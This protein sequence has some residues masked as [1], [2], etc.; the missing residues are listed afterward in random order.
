MTGDHASPNSLYQ[1]QPFGRT[2]VL[3][4]FAPADIS[5][6]PLLP[7]RTAQILRKEWDRRASGS[8]SLIDVIPAEDT[9][10]IRFDDAIDQASVDQLDQLIGNAQTSGAAIPIPPTIV[11][12]PVVI[13]VTYNGADLADISAQCGISVDRLIDTHVNTDFTVAF[14][15]FAP[16]FAYLTG[17]PDA[18]H[19]PRRHTPRTRVPAGSVAIAEHYSAV[20]PQESPGGWHLIGHTDLTLFDPRHDAPPLLRPGMTV[21]FAHAGERIEIA[22]D[23]LSSAAST[24]PTATLSPEP[25]ASTPAGARIHATGMGCVIEDLGRPGWGHLAISESGAW[26]R[27]SHRLAQRLV[28]NDENAAGL[29]CVAGGLHLR[30][31]EP[32]TVAITGAPG[33]AWISRADTDIAVSTHIPL[34]LAAGESLRIGMPTSGLRRYVAIRGGIQAMSMFDSRSTD[35]LSGLGPAPLDAGAHLHFGQATHEVPGIDAMAPDPV[36]SDAAMIPTAN[37]SLLHPATREHLASGSFHMSAASDRVGIRLV[38]PAAQWLPD[39]RVT[40]L[41]RPMI[42][43]AIQMPPDG[44]PVVFGPDHPA[45]GGYPIIGVLADPDAPAQ[46]APG[47]TV[48]L[49]EVIPFHLA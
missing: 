15:G 43:G 18:L 40:A 23:P 4:T 47:V 48:A 32:L 42:R 39:A 22:S 29:E 12:A 13:P 26:D 8:T 25:H 49:N 37:W 19:V 16:G 44:Q 5:A 10:L 30:A 38:G 28:G 31:L 20:Y 24:Q 7:D 27:R 6:N 11:S 2:A 17:L 3:V 21:R 36:S 45:T 1:L 46:W 35:T 14:C 41:S 34:Y 33:P 9:L